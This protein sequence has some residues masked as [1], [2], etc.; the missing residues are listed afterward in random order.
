MP[1]NAN[2]INTSLVT[3][4]AVKEF[5]NSMQMLAKCDRQLDDQ[6]KKVGQSIDVRRPVMWE[7]TDGATISS[8]DEA[9]EGSVSVTLNKRKKVAF[10]FTTQ[11]LTLEIDDFN[12]RYIKPAMIEL[13]QKVESDI[14]DVYKE[15][16]NFVG[17]P[18]TAPANFLA[19]GAARAKLNKLG[20]PMGEAKAAFYEPDAALALANS[21]QNVFP[22]QIAKRAIEEAMITKYAQFEIFENQS[23]KTHTTGTY[24]AGS[25]P[26]I[27]GAAQNVTYAASKDS[28]TQTLL[29]D[30]WVVST[31]DVLKEGDVFTIAGVNA[32]NRR[33]REDTGDLAQFVVRADATTDGTVGGPL[34]LT[35]APAIIV[36]GPYQ[37]VT[38]A[39]ADGAAITMVTGTQ[40]T[41]YPQN[42]AFHRNAITVAMAPLV[43]PPGNVEAS[44]ESF[45]GISIRSVRD[46]DII[47]DEGLWR[48]DILYAVKAQ[49]PGFAVRT[50]S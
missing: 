42:L 45:E 6:F 40:A 32:V 31:A 15:I 29:T 8:F 36:D 41:G 16:F 21:L 37:T 38:A 35:I 46:Y 22:Q 18:G 19:V 26:L 49:N 4:F 13:A 47:E 5:V 1:D 28:G 30:G 14:A 43:L 11:D 7:A 12:E 23:L 34:S 24:T 33:S 44:S 50:T 39:P 20:V 17:T 3:K 25:T 27:N 48:F 9:E 10:S 2:L